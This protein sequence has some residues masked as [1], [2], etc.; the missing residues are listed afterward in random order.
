MVEQKPS[1]SDEEGFLGAVGDT[2]EQLLNLFFGEPVE[3]VEE[4]K[5]TP[6]EDLRAIIKEQADQVLAGLTLR[7]RLVLDLRYGLEDGHARTL[8]EAGR[9]P[10]INR[11]PSTVWRIE[12]QALA[13]VRSPGPRKTLKDY[14]EEP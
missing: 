9:D 3:G 7:E 1:N 2:D 11:S 4:I 8:R 14:L 5:L 10:R 6:P 12:H 13:R